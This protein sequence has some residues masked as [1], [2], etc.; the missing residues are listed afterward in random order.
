M[1]KNAIGNRLELEADP[2]HPARHQRTA[3]LDPVAG[4]NPFL[5]IKRQTIGVFG[6]GDLG[7]ER[8]RRH[9]CLDDMGRRLRLNDRLMARLAGVF[10]AVRDDHPEPRRDHVKT[11]AHV[12]CDLDPVARPAP[13][14]EYLRLECHV[15]PFEMGSKRFALPRGFLA[16]RRL[17]IKFRLDR[18]QPGLDLIEGKVELTIS[19]PLRAAT[20]A[21]PF[22]RLEQRV[23]PRDPHLGIVVDRLQPG[24]LAGHRQHHR[25]E[26]INVV[27]E[28]RDCDRHRWNQT[29]KPAFWLGFSGRLIQ[30]AAPIQAIAAAAAA[31]HESASSPSRRQAPSAAPNSG[32]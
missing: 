15:D 16:F 19:Q 18:A 32:G 9:A 29:T 4:I 3:E 6:D 26:R 24:D 23:Q 14:G 2:P 11:F 10:G 31:A 5:A 1:V 17:L 22:Q 20:V 30:H 7:Q 12:F 8:F 13:T 27:R 28:G 25:L 21:R